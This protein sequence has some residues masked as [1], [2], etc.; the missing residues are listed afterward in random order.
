M[1]SF[2]R[3]SLIV[4]S[5]SLAL[6]SVPITLGDLPYMHNVDFA[7]RES[8]MFDS[9][10]LLSVAMQA[11]F[12]WEA[13][14]R[15]RQKSTS[16][17]SSSSQG[18]GS[19]GSS[20]TKKRTAPSP[21]VIKGLGSAPALKVA[22]TTGKK[23]DI[24]EATI[25]INPYAGDASKLHEHFT[26]TI[27]TQVLLAD[28]G[29][30]PD[31]TFQFNA[32]FADFLQ[33]Q[34]EI[35]RRE[36][37]ADPQNAEKQETADMFPANMDELSRERGIKVRVTANHDPDSVGFTPWRVVFYTDQG[38]DGLNSLLLLLDS[39]ITHRLSQPDFAPRRQPVI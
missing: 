33:S 25:V 35:L 27:C 17:A 37:A 16:A 1:E 12:I 15:P 34:K 4:L 14:F 28:K 2:C 10:M 31:L 39:Y 7:I 32:S 23:S 20:P 11:F 21:A 18:G 5:I 3:A 26:P 36:A 13:M 8:M 6:C 24:G 30:R 29:G 22:R 38:L 9:M 19:G